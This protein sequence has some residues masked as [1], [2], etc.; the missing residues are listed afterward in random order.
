MHVHQCK[1]AKHNTCILLDQSPQEATIVVSSTHVQRLSG[2]GRSSALV[3]RLNLA[4]KTIF[5]EH[6]VFG[7]TFWLDLSSS[8]R[9]EKSGLNWGHLQF[10]SMLEALCHKHVTQFQHAV[11]GLDS[12]F[13]NTYI[14]VYIYIYIYTVCCA[15]SMLHSSNL[16][17]TVRLLVVVDVVVLHTRTNRKWT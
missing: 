10:T 7:P 15:Q 3:S 14:H 17:H 16:E 9:V 2:R 6:T 5:C 1:S 13:T 8:G 12:E 4:W 11:G